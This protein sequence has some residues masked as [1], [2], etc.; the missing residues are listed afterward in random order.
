MTAS[1]QAVATT[2]SQTPNSI[3]YIGIG[4]IGSG[5]LKEV[6]VNNVEAS[7]KTVKDKTYPISRTLQ[8]Y[9]NGKPA[10]DV[11]KFIDFILSKKGQELVVESG[12]IK[13]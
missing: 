8:M 13:L 6:K 1:N 3:G 12:F 4:Y 10:G 11:K 5:K 9:T 7:E 2:V